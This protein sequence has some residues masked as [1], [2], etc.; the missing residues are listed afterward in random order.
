MNTW[1]LITTPDKRKKYGLRM[2]THSIFSVNK[3]T[4]A[5]YKIKRIYPKKKILVLKRTCKIIK[6]I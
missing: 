5:V 6:E 4:P 1:F 2:L 3:I